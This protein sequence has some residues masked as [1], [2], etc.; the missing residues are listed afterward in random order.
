MSLGKT[1]VKT[2]T[3]PRKE[4]MKDDT[5]SALLPELKKVGKE[6]LSR[7]NWDTWWCW[8]N[9]RQRTILPKSKGGKYW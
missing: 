8:N 4:K 3:N 2:L 1:S 5:W 7:E 9:L 6:D